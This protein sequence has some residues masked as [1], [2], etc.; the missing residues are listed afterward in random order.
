[1]AN[2]SFSLQIKARL[3]NLDEDIFPLPYSRAAPSIP[4]QR[5]FPW[6]VCS[7]LAELNSDMSSPKEIV[8]TYKDNRKLIPILAHG[9]DLCP[10]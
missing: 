6:L 1:M 7:A 2:D 8:F 10:I 3:Q 4:L 5:K 9:V